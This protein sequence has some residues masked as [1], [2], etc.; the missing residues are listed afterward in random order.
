MWFVKTSVG[1][2]RHK[3]RCFVPKKCRNW[4]LKS[5][6]PASGSQLWQNLNSLINI[7]LSVWPAVCLLRSVNQ[8]I[9]GLSTILLR[10]AEFLI[11]KLLYTNITNHKSSAR[12]ETLLS[13]RQGKLIFKRNIKILQKWL[14]T[15]YARQSAWNSY[16]LHV[17]FFLFLVIF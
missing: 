13:K 17:S 8:G 10:T 14:Y 15:S 9:N 6:W 16:C 5:N 11:I 4:S 2:K 1:W 3:N 12:I 7:L